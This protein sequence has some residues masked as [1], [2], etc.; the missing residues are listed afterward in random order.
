[1]CLFPKR[2]F[3]FNSPAYKAG[4]TEFECGKCPECLAKKARYWALRATYQ[5]KDM[6]SCMI[7]LTYDSYIYDKHGRPIGERPPQELHVCKRDAQLFIKR[8]RKHFSGQAIKYILTAE[9]G[10][11][12][13]R[14]HYHALLFGIE[15]NDL[16]R[17]KRSKRGNWIYKSKTLTDIWQNGICTVDAIKCKASV[18]RYC[19]K[20]ACKDA[21]AD[22][23]FMLFSRDIGTAGLL[24]D[25]NGKSYICDGREYPIPRQIWQH[26]ITDRYRIEYP[27]YRSHGWIFDHYSTLPYICWIFPNGVEAYRSI[28]HDVEDYYYDR[29]VRY[30]DKRN[31]D[32]QYQAY[33][34]YW[35]EKADKNPFKQVS[36]YERLLALPNDKYY[37]YKQKSLQYLQDRKLGI[38]V[39]VPRS[40]THSRFMEQLVDFAY[41]DDLPFFD[42]SDD[43]QKAFIRNLENLPLTSRHPTANDTDNPTIV[44]DFVKLRRKFYSTIFDRNGELTDLAFNLLFYGDF[45]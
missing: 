30:R 4:V 6:P 26:V 20:Y 23:T 18:A 16:M 5:A 12:T 7:T 41:S 17:Y 43:G 2:N 35:S 33:L 15:F 24:R 32:E 8:L 34:A 1:M 11:R 21:G 29:R 14:A 9:Y 38:K 45:A 28:A 25:F 19:T 13:H 10:K 37:S 42:L 22:D 27:V 3:N 44:D 40:T 36:A 31:N 39:N